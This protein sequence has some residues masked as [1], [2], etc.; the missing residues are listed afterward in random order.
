MLVTIHSFVPVFMGVYR[1]VEIGILHGHDRRL[2]DYFL[3]Q[4][5]SHPAYV[6]RRNEPYGPAD[7]VTHTL[8]WAGGG[9]DLPNVMIEIRSDLI[10]K[11]AGI[12][13][14]A[15][16]VADCLS[17]KLYQPQFACSTRQ[18]A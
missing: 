12:T 14:V 3:D 16:W 7:G 4:A 13:Q 6:L 8:D 9:Y 1:A 10:A 18:S 5:K 15:Q 17:D 2:A 11:K